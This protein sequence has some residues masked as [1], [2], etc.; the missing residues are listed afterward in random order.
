GGFRLL[1][2]QFVDRLIAIA[3]P[4]ETRSA[5]VEQ[6]D[7]LSAAG[8]QV[9]ANREFLAHDFGEV[10]RGVDQLELAVEI[11]LL[12]LVD[13]DDRRI[14]IDRQVA[15]LRYQDPEEMPDS[16]FSTTSMSGWFPRNSRI[17]P[18]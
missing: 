12:Q 2:E 11:D 1:L 17:Y 4:I 14:A 13:Q 9:E 6:V 18:R 7:R 8:L 15:R 10:A 3:V 16:A 5:G